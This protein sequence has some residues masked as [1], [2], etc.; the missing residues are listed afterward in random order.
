MFRNTMTCLPCLPQ[1]EYCLGGESCA[2]AKCYDYSR[3]DGEKYKCICTEGSYYDTLFKKCFNCP[4]QNCLGCADL[5]NE[6]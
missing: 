6:H 3:F 1:C 2:D 4:D 5:E